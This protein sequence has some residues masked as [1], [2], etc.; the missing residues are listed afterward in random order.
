MHRI[1]QEDQNNFL[2]DQ[3]SRFWLTSVIRA[4]G[5][6]QKRH[7]RLHRRCPPTPGNCDHNAPHSSCRACDRIA[8][9]VS[10]PLRTYGSHDVFPG[11]SRTV[12]W[13]LGEKCENDHC[14]KESD[15]GRRRTWIRLEIDR[16]APPNGAFERS[17]G[18]LCTFVQTVP[19]LFENSNVANADMAPEEGTRR[20]HRA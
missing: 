16:E 1:G 8:G 13:L 17:L 5:R 12:V 18:P 11:T 6:R 10:A 20:R 14:W 4:P 7:G 19:R 15:G 9:Y 3:M 2:T